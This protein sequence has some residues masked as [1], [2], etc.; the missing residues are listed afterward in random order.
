MKMRTLILIAAAVLFA[1]AGF[2]F[3]NGPHAVRGSGQSVVVLCSSCSFE[4]IPGGSGYLV[5][6]DSNSGDVWLYSDGAME[7]KENPIRWGKLVLG[8]KLVRTAP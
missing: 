4:G 8:Q 2:L 3:W 6:M 7:G 1:I 5:L